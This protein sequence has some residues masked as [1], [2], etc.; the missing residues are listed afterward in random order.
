M[1][2]LYL[3]I[4]V[5]ISSTGYSSTLLRLNVETI[6]R[7]KI[8]EGLVITS[9]HHF[10]KE[11]LSGEKISESLNKDLAITIEAKFIDMVD[12][13]MNPTNKVYVK[14]VLKYSGLA[15]KNEF[16][17]PKQTSSLNEKKFLNIKIT[18]K[19]SVDLIF[20]VQMEDINGL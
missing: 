5:V 6:I 8:D 9:E 7:N 1:K 10:S 20:Y 13:E 17:I 14:G 19:K 18:D 16:E 11:I 12:T 4:L 15:L 3:I 2:S